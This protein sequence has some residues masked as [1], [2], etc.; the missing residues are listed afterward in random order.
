MIQTCALPDWHS[1]NKRTVT[2]EELHSQ[3]AGAATS[4]DTCQWLRSTST[5]Q[6]SI[7]WNSC[8]PML[9]DPHIHQETMNVQSFTL[10]VFIFIYISKLAPWMPH[11]IA[12]PL[13]NTPYGIPQFQF[14]SPGWQTSN[15]M[16]LAMPLIESTQLSSMVTTHNQS[17]VYQKRHSLAIL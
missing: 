5:N 2:F 14:Y 7:N 15:H 12:F 6:S 3:M 10:I 13:T 1:R 11:N 9:S 8:M 17:G 4:K 16:S